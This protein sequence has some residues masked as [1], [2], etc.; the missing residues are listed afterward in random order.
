MF[1]N[2]TD[3]MSL[4]V[5]LFSNNEIAGVLQLNLVDVRYHRS[6]RNNLRFC[7]SIL[8]EVGNFRYYKASPKFLLKQCPLKY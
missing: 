3:C 7:Y 1:K 5:E 6:F 4:K 2:V 8:H